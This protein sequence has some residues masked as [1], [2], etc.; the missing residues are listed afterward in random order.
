MQWL[1]LLLRVCSTKERFVLPSKKI[2]AFIAGN[3]KSDDFVKSLLTNPRLK[4]SD[5]EYQKGLFEEVQARYRKHDLFP[6]VRTHY[7]RMAFQIPGD[8][9]IRISLDLEIRM[10]SEW[11]CPPGHWRSEKPEE[12]FIYTFPYGIME[13]KL[14]G[15]LDTMPSWIKELMN[16]KFCEQV[17]GCVWG[18]SLN[19]EFREVRRWDLKGEG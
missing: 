3:Y 15:P 13:V 11:H 9:R 17:L 10:M 1:Q 4:P 19:S 2:D 5:V 8:A 18:S 12:E 14:Q 7:P 6:S 16:S